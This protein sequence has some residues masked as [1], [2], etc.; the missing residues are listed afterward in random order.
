MEIYMAYDEKAKERTMR[1]LEKQKQIRFWVN[2]ADYERFENEAKN[3]GY[4][5]LRQFYL[6]AIEEKIKNIKENS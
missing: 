1:Y 5:S 4:K 2:P 3:A 6:D